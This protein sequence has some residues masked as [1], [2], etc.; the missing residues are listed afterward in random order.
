MKVHTDLCDSRT[1]CDACE[2]DLGDTWVIPGPCA[3][4]L[5]LAPLLPCAAP[6]GACTLYDLRFMLKMQPVQSAGYGA[7]AY[8]RPLFGS[9]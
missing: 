9:K 4:G 2:S 1:L 7:G 8:T 3:R 5:D 6:E